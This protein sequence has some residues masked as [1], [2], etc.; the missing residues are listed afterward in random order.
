[1]IVNTAR[2]VLV[3]LT[4]LVSSNAYCFIDPP[5]FTPT[6]PTAGQEV[7]INVRFGVCD[8]YLSAPPTITYSATSIEIIYQTAT[9]GYCNIP[10]ATLTTSLGALAAGT[11]SIVIKR[12]N[13]FFG[14]PPVL[15][16]V[17]TYTLLVQQ[18]VAATPVPTLEPGFML[19]MI[20]A[21]LLVV[22]TIRRRNISASGKV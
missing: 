6:N 7:L 18:A 11:Y 2:R 12:N 16:L 21:L 5:T 10:I 3:L 19:F 14:P 4:L 22:A 15:S 8:G 1:M 9:S 17:G 13:T 20:L